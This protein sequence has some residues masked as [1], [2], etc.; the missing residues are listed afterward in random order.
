MPR[1]NSAASLTARGV[2][3]GADEDSHGISKGLSVPSTLWRGESDEDQSATGLDLGLYCEAE[4]QLGDA[5]AHVS[6]QDVNLRAVRPCFGGSDEAT[7]TRGFASP[8]R[9]AL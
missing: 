5:R 4:W 6:S 9:V 2:L 3:R 8:A 1:A 7:D